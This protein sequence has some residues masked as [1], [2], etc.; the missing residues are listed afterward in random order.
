MSG[1]DNGLWLPTLDLPTA[2]FRVIGPGADFPV[3]AV[4]EGGYVAYSP[5]LTDAE[6]VPLVVVWTEGAPGE[7]FVVEAPPGCVTPST[8]AGGTIPPG[9]LPAATAVVAGEP[10]V[11][12]STVPPAAP[13]ER[14]R[15]GLDG[16]ILIVAL[17]AAA[18]V[19]MIFRSY[20][21][22]TARDQLG[23]GLDPYVTPPG[24]P[25]PSPYT[26]PP[27]QPTTATQAASWWSTKQVPATRPPA[28]TPTITEPAEP[29][30]TLDGSD[31]ATDEYARQ[32]G[33]WLG[34]Q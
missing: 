12:A 2:P 5:G 1:C 20:R 14:G 30:T 6:A 24:P 32:L 7:V 8:I 34:K 15:S 25:R 19:T 11:A 33:E 28:R 4:A 10:S 22:E 29:P 3:A 18:I 23:T 9:T 17:A 21:R 26:P 31:P 16:L 13:A 27:P